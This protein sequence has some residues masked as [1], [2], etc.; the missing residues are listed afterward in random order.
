MLTDDLSFQKRLYSEYLSP[1]GMVEQ[2]GY[3]PEG[4]GI[5]LQG[6]TPVFYEEDLPQDITQAA[7]AIKANYK[8]GALQ[9]QVQFHLVLPFFR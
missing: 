4:K 5:H 2:T 3:G 1:D 7:Q 8:S 9:F 6:T